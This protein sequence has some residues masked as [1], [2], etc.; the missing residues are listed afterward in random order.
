MWITYGFLWCFYQLFE[1]SFWRHPFTAEDPLAVNF[2]KS[3]LV[4]KQ[5]HLH[6]DEQIFTFGWAISLIH[7]IPRLLKLYNSF[8]W[9]MGLDLNHYALIIPLHLSTPQIMLDHVTLT[10]PSLKKTKNN[11]RQSCLIL[12]C[13]S[14]TPNLNL[15]AGRR[16]EWL[17][18]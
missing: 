14:F 7:Y 9:W 6:Q 15:V 16:Y 17:K 4:T 1:L 2:P 5:I 3:L 8:V 12:R 11:C 18:Y 13:I 10:S